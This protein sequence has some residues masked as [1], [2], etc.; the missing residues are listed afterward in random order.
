MTVSAHI[1]SMQEM[2]SK[3]TDAEYLPPAGVEAERS[4]WDRTA[5]NT[6]DEM[7]IIMDESSSMSTE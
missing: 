4:M 3:Q 5:R 7:E 1:A 2:N 6:I